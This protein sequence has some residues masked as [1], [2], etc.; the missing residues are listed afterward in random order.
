M[1]FNYVHPELTNTFLYMYALTLYT[2]ELH[3]QQQV[4]HPKLIDRL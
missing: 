3:N 2:R 4:N 1:Y